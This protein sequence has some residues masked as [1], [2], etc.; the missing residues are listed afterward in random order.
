MD[1]HMTNINEVVEQH[2][3]QHESR[4]NHIDEML[5]TARQAAV[6]EGGE[7][8]HS[9]VLA[10]LES[11]REKLADHIEEIK[12]DPAGYWQKTVHEKAG[13]MGVWDAVAERL[14]KFLERLGGGKGSG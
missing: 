4:L 8:H 1:R 10:A 14:E 7:E 12:R 5:A 11:D 9:D 6:A 3:L 2:I 13:P